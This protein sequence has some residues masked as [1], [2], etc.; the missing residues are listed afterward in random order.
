MTKTIFFLG[1]KDL[2]MLTIKELFEA[3]N[4]DYIDKNLSWGA[5][6][7]SYEDELKKYQDYTI[8]GIELEQDITPP[9]NYNEIDHH[10]QNSNRLSS[11]E[12]VAKILDIKLNR[13]QK[14]VAL[15]DS[16]YI[17]AMRE[18]GATKEEIKSI[19]AKDRLAQGV[20]KKDEELAI[21]S[22]K[23]ADNN[24]IYSYTS[25]FS[26][27]CDMVFEEYDSYIIY[28]D[29]KTLFYGYNQKDIIEYLK[30]KSLTKDN[31][32]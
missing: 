9:P 7:S 3:N 25:H 4:I 5:K 1:G 24:K 17:K 12:Q 32:Y 15:N 14:L 11:I 28:N 31:Y 13:Y 8:Y 29:T 10:N 26:T 30:Q 27:I 20:S 6:L 16:G 2:E 21:Q 19:R 22:L 18:F 23:E